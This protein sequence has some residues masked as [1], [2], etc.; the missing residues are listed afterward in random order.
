M[1][2]NFLNKSKPINFIGVLIF[3]LVGLFYT[4]F[5]DGFTSDKLVKSTIL[6]LCFLSIFFIFNF[7][8]NKNDLTFDNSYAYFLFVL[9]LLSI[10][11]EL[12][13]YLILLKTF[14][15]LLFLRKIYS[16]HS[17]RKTIEKFFDGGFWLGILFIL[18]PFSILFL[19][20]I[21]IAIYIHNKITIQSIFIPIIGF[22]TPLIIYFTYLFGQDNLD[23]FTKLFE[24][25]FIFNLEFYTQSNY[26]WFINS[27]LFFT[28]LSIF[29]KSIKALSINNTFRKNWIV[30]LTNFTIIFVFLAYLP[31]KT[32]SELVYIF[33]PTAIILA[34][35]IELI[36]KKIV[37]DSLLYLFLAATIVV[38]YFL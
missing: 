34:N 5:Q 1:L 22:I 36:Q 13:E 38:H 23:I 35:G 3:F 37:K 12:I 11:S 17:S 14:I 31:E 20:F 26:L 9:L 19:V 10:S 32:G 15:Y 24:F 27:V 30:L 2:A 29:I 18:E 6:S 7:I 21:Y 4:I 8:N 25:N 16:L 28:F 33:L